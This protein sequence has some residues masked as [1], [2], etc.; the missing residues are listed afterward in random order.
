MV[1]TVSKESNASFRRLPSWFRQELPNTSKINEMK[2]LFRGSRLHTVCESAHCPNMGKC[3]GQGV[4]TF[5]ILGDTCTRACRFCAIPAGRPTELDLAE[6]KNVAL[7]VKELNLRYVV[8]TSVARD[9]LQ[10]KG[11]SQ[12]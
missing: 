7:A 1:E 6:P 10:D 11:A 9:D 3:W 2:S 12:F 5:M 8:V 4:A